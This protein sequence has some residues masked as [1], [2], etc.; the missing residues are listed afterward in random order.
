MSNASSAIARNASKCS[1]EKG[2]L[3]AYAAVTISISGIGGIEDWV[4]SVE[5]LMV[6][7]RTLQVCTA[8]MWHGFSIIKTMT[9]GMVKF[10]ERKGYKTLDE[11]IGKALPRIT[12]WT[13]LTK[14]PPVVA[15]VIEE[16]VI[17][18]A[19]VLGGDPAS[20]WCAS[21]PLP[22]D[23]DEYLL[24]GFLRGSPVEF[25]DCISQP[26]EVPANAEIVPRFAA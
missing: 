26:L 11:M 10:M 3:T 1:G 8:V 2:R 17:P 19:I 23:I 4:S 12:T 18:A 5:Y 16:D 22:P 15:K 6:G 9:E 24:A 21:A 7:A 25:I 13:A 20:M 14:L